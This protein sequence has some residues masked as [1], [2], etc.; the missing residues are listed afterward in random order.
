MVKL[1]PP[2]YSLWN[3]VS[4]AIGK[5]VNIQVLGLNVSSEPYKITIITDNESKGQALSTILVPKHQFGH[6]TVTVSVQNCTGEQFQGL[7]VSSVTDLVDIF[8]EALRDNDL[9]VNA[10]SKPISPLPNAPVYVYPVFMKEVIQFFNDDLTDLYNN[11]NNV[12]ANVFRNIL[13]TTINGITIG[14]SSEE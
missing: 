7:S 5:D 4:H 14:Y 3:E 1:S 2:W 8:K 10:I 12:A 9:F 6:I 13:K 11:Y